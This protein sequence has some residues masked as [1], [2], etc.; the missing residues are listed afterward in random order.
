MRKLLSIAIVSLLPLTLVSQT[1]PP[2][3]VG[4]LS[5]TTGLIIPDSVTRML[6][7]HSSGDRA[8]DHVQRIALWDRQQETVGYHEAADWVARQ[9][10]ELGL[11]KVAVEQYASDGETSY[12]GDT[13]SPVWVAKRGE[14]WVESPYSYKITSYADLPMSLAQHSSSTETTARLVDVGA[15]TDDDYAGKDVT[16]SIVLT[17]TYPSLAVRKAVWEQGA[18]GVISS[19]SIPYWDQTNRREGD[20]MDQVGW[21]GVPMAEDTTQEAFAFMVSQRKANELKELLKE[22]E[23]TLRVDID[24]EHRADSFG[25]VSGIIEGTT[26]PDEEIIIT[27][28]LDHYKPGANDN[29]SGSAVAL[30]MIR[31]LTSLVEQNKVPRPLRT[32]RFLWLPEFTGTKAWFARHVKEDKQRILNINLDMLGADLKES[33]S[34]FDVSYTPDWNASYVNAFSAS[35]IDFLN[36][37]NGTKYPRRKDFHIISVNGSRHPMRA[38]MEPYTRGSDHQIFNDFGI[39]GIIYGTW[40]DN[41]YHSSGD[42]PDKVDPT[43][44]HRV[45]FTGLASILMTAYANEASAEGIINLVDLYEQERLKEDEFRARQGMLS[46]TDST[47]DNQAYFS[48]RTIHYGYERAKKALESCRLFSD[49]TVAGKLINDKKAAYGER[50]KLAQQ[51]LLA[52]YRRSR[53]RPPSDVPIR[54][55]TAQE[56]SARQTIPVRTK[57]K[58]LNSFY[59]TYDSLGEAY[60]AEYQTVYRELDKVLAILRERETGELRIYQF[61][62]VIGSYINGQRSVLDIR[63]ALYAEYQVE[64][65]L[66]LINRIFDLLET[67]GVISQGK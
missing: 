57:G 4:P 66:G 62:D 25:I 18:L 20:F 40:P 38:T 19:F 56:D 64:V 61:E 37:Y 60:E 21:G 29:A 51:E 33:D 46:A 15:G 43:Q 13:P 2:P 14:L 17:S 67:G 26:Y 30:E 65:P 42:T 11:Q 55:L 48:S 36:Q 1:P 9:A 49:D 39:P 54:P 24:T 5:P 12:F 35:I 8:H 28:H 23:V 44:L 63:D 53:T 31:T 52:L 58:E 45:I 27:A 50:E 10:A 3:L 34:F 47:I 7:H 16:R 22:E 59:S 6:I 32:I 41:H